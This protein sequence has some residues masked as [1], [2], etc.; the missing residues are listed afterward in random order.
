MIS[1][2]ISGLEAGTAFGYQIWLVFFAAMAGALRGLSL[3]V[4]LQGAQSLYPRP[5]IE[6]RP[7]PLSRSEA[8][9]WSARRR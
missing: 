5:E 3:A 1:G 2:L 8:P 6:R 9:I 4:L 7:D